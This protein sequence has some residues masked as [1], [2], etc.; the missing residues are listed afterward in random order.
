MAIYGGQIKLTT[1]FNWL[2]QE[3]FSRL[4]RGTNAGLALAVPTV[5]CLFIHSIV[6]VHYLVFK[7]LNVLCAVNMF[8]EHLFSPL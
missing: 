1:V 5:S 2:F 8:V 4:W 3:G 6:L 7:T